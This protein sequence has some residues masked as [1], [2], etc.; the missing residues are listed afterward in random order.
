MAFVARTRTE[1]R[2]DLIAS[3]STRYLAEGRR[4]ATWQ[5]SPAY[6][7]ADAFSVVL[8][9]LDQQA[10]AV[11]R[12]ILPDTA[13]GASLDRHGYV[14]G[15]ERRPATKAV[16]TVTVT[17]T[18]SATIAIPAGSTMSYSGSGALFDV[19]SSSVTFSGGGISTVLVRARS[20]GTDGNLSASTVLVWTTPPA[21]INTQGVVSSILTTAEGAETDADYSAR[22]IARLR[23]RPA[24]GNRADWLDWTETV[25]GIGEAYVNPLAQP[26]TTTAPVLGCVTVVAVTPPP[27]TYEPQTVTAIAVATHGL[28]PSYSRVPSAAVLANAEAYIEGTQDA[29]GRPLDE[30]AQV[31][32]RPV[33]MA[34]GDYA[35][36]APSVSPV[37]CTVDVATDETRYP[38][39]F[40]GSRT[41]QASPTP[42]TSTFTLDDVTDIGAGDMVAVE[43]GASIRGRMWLCAVTQVVGSAIT[44]S[45]ACPAAPSAG[46]DVY[47]D[48]GVWAGVRQTILQEF[49]GLGPGAVSGST[50]YP[51]TSTRGPSTL[52]V[53]RLTARVVSVDGVT[54]CTMT[55]PTTDTAA[56]AKQILTPSAIVIQKL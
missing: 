16:L 35:V 24:S 44:V 9:T 45:P 49:D 18:P 17:G 15:V 28:S 33:T 52:S 22:I 32:L 27:T 55:G 5:G 2:D 46:A 21:G 10:Q 53:A 48:P 36:E 42:T 20:A 47:P 12:D 26:G 54:S 51:S 50:R 41:V 39:P 7:M 3:W 29:Q 43:V 30:T 13:A 14:Y 4:L 31:Q 56:T 38:W 11:T 25:D 8:A 1:I 23:D 37:T 34:A 6:M 19:T 40:T